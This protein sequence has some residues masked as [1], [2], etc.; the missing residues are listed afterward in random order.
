MVRDVSSPS[1]RLSN[2]ADCQI[3]AR[4]NISPSSNAALQVHNY[5]RRHRHCGAAYRPPSLAVMPVMSTS[6]G[7]MPNTGHAGL[8][9]KQRRPSNTLNLRTPKICTLQY[10][11]ELLRAHMWAQYLPYCA[12]TCSRNACASAAASASAAISSGSS[13]LS[14]H[15][16][17]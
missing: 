5:R 12:A 4:T 15:A 14:S 8:K 1:N 11:T 13:V 3:V 6:S 7:E 2:T 10:N 9:F 16:L 17:P